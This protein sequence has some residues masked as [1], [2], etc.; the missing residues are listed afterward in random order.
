MRFYERFCSFCALCI[1]GKCTS[2]HLFAYGGLVF[3]TCAAVA[4]A[5][6]NKLSRFLCNQ[7]YYNIASRA[8]QS[9]SIYVSVLK[10]PIVHADDVIYE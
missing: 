3:K 8:A 6:E 2:R 9:N 10:I 7:E 5:N 1:I 4:P